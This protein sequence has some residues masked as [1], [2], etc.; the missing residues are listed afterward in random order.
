MLQ[1]DAPDSARP[2]AHPAAPG[3]AD[4]PEWADDYGTWIQLSPEPNASLSSNGFGFPMAVKANIAVRG[5]T[6]SAGSPTLSGR[7]AEHDAG[8]VAALRAAGAEVAGMTNMHELAFGITSNNAYFGPVRHPLDNQACAGGSSGGSAAAVAR[9]YVP[10]ALGTDT[11]GSVSVPASVC[12]VVGFR[13]TT[14]RWPTDG[15]IGLSWTRDTIG[16]LASS[17]ADAAWTDSVITREHGAAP[18]S[19]LRLAVAQEHVADLDP[20]T[21]SATDQAV[22]AL[23]EHV[24]VVEFPRMLDLDEFAAHQWVTVAYESRRILTGVAAEAWGLAPDTAVQ[25]L[26]NRV[27]SPDVAATLDAV[28]DDPITE[29]DYGNACASI[30]AARQDYASALEEA[31]IDALVVPTTP[32]PATPV[33]IDQVITHCGKDEAIFGLM[34]RNTVG[35]TLLR[36]PMLTVPIPVDTDHLPVGLTLQGKAF[37]DARVLG[38]G[39]LVERWLGRSQT[40]VPDQMC[41]RES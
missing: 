6:Q 14:G 30:W 19:P 7:V 33:G 39:R 35:G 15:T 9:G 13:P 24:E 11:G 36:A 26:R 23:R 34:T 25:M 28:L 3:Q 21:R 4:P 40:A 16:V 5:M 29:K 32:R 37:D 20:H 10:L 31:G 12:G 27:A 22:A 1:P 41:G 2:E 18:R 38:M 17:V 8:V